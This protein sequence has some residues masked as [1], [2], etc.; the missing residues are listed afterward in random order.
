MSPTQIVTQVR[1]LVSEGQVPKS[2][3]ALA[4]GLSI[5]ALNYLLDELWNP[6]LRTLVALERYLVNRDG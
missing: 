3:I 5:N 1:S 4:S 6:R 2:Q